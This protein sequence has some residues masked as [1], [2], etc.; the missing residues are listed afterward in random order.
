MGGLDAVFRPRSVAVVGASTRPGKL[1]HE[2]LRNLLEAGFG[3]EVYPVNPKADE[4]LGVR[5]YRSVSE[6]P[7]PVDLA[8]MVIPA[9]LVPGAV[10][11]AAA[12][13][14]RGFVVVS[15][16]FR[17]S[18]PEGAELER[19]LVEAVRGAG[20]RLVGPNCQGVANPHA[21]LCATWPLVTR[22]GRV[23]VVSQS[24]TVAAFLA[25]SLEEHGVGMSKLAALG[26]KADVDEVDVLEFLAGDPE[27]EV[28]ALY[29]EGVAGGRGRDLMEAV[30]RCVEAGKAV[31]ALK[32]G[33]TE[34]GSR[35]VASHTGSVAGAAEVYE[36][37]FRQAG[38]IPA[39]SL[40][41]ML[42]A[43]EAL[44]AHPPMRGDSVAVVTSSG[45]GG[46]LAVDALESRGL[47]AAELSGETL[48]ALRES[49][50]GYAVVGNPLDL[51]GSATA[52]DYDAALAALSRDP[53]V[54]GILAIFGDPIPGAFEV[55][56]R[57]REGLG[58]RPLVAAYLGGGEV[59]AAELGKFRGAG[60]PVFPT[61]ERAAAALAAL[62]D[63][64]RGSA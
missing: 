14:A 49:L 8:V 4:I 36:A 21:G 19:R 9:R 5:C 23:A 6:V 41:E 26:N 58:G 53:G 43:A 63:V 50:P 35:A 38:A 11:E 7:G 62:R 16:G 45:G 2:I 33:R 29:V 34:A 25:T 59:Q 18:G 20:G 31:V 17:E 22:R 13:G 42:D 3:G 56:S 1:G 47:R 39:S 30:R 28:V 52:A 27:T 44:A 57:W 55:V 10:E 40:E 12:R 48:A 32:A 51:T 15:G 24:G 60:I 64:G 46:I 54:D 37:A 61:P